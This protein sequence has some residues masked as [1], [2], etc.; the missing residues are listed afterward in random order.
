MANTLRKILV[1]GPML[2]LLAMLILPKREPTQPQ[3]NAITTPPVAG[4]APPEE[5]NPA[6]PHSPTAPQSKPASDRGTSKT[7][8]QTPE[9]TSESPR[10]SG[11]GVVEKV[12]MDHFA[13]HPDTEARILHLKSLEHNGA[14]VPAVSDD[15]VDLAIDLKNRLAR[16]ANT[17]VGEVAGP[18]TL[19]EEW[20]L[21]RQVHDKLLESAE[22]DIAETA[23]ITRLAMPLL[24]S[25]AR[26]KDRPYS[27]TVLK[28]D[29]VNAFAHLG[30]HVYVC[31]GL[32]E[33]IENDKQLEFVLGHEIGHVERAHCAKASLPGVA[34]ERLVGSFA[35]LPADALQKLVGL[36]YSEGDELDADAWSYKVL[37]ARNYQLDDILGFFR[38][39]KHYEQS[40]ANSQ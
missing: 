6:L 36:S 27:F 21:G 1:F 3:V 15:M 25:C 5:T 9:S 19:D 2:A 29:E 14:Y 10:L 17:V 11:L 38:I 20:R 37:K 12:V 39:L 30:G 7:D 22:I 24:E 16:A 26:T 8:S 31:S 33:L 32:L 18:L 4:S 34:A 35:K 13:S 28:D 40:L 23:R